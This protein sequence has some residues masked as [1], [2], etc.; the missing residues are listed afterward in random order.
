V[1]PYGAEA[2]DQNRQLFGLWN[3]QLSKL[4]QGFRRASLQQ[5]LQSDNGAAGSCAELVNAVA[6]HIGRLGEGVIQ[7]IFNRYRL[8]IGVIGADIWTR[9]VDIFVAVEKPGKS[10]YDLPV[11]LRREIPFGDDPRFSAAIR[12]SLQRS[13]GS[14]APG[15][16]RL[17]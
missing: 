15:W 9:Q 3:I 11:F 1:W 5:G 17:G 4:G 6:A 14:P 13:S 10:L 12:S 7:T 8:H 16:D 2:L